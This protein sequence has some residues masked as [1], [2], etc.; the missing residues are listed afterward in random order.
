MFSISYSTLVL[1]L[2]SLHVKMK[3]SETSLE[4]TVASKLQDIPA[5]FPSLATL[6]VW[7]T[8][9]KCFKWF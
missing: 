9:K 8:I 2:L 5:L 6:S 4:F 1:R 3:F 7:W